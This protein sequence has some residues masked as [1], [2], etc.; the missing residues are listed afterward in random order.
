MKHYHFSFGNSTKG[1]IGLCAEVAADTQ[2]EAV[3]VL[4]NALADTLGPLGMLPI[5]LEQPSVEYVNVYINP[6]YI[7][8][9]EIEE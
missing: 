3:S 6:D 4:R 8:A 5:S 2:Q 7:G 1:P 9:S